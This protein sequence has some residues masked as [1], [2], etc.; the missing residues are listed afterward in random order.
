MSMDKLAS[1]GGMVWDVEVELHGEH[2]VITVQPG[3]SILESAEMAGLTLSYEC[4]RGNCTSCAAKILHGSS[5]FV[6]T[7]AEKRSGTSDPEGY[8]LTCC[9]FPVGPG[10]KLSLGRNPDMWEDFCAR[11]TQ[12]ETREML[13]E[14]SSEI[15]MDYANKYPEEL[16]EYLSRQMPE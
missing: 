8:V 14:A 7:H 4:R 13:S 2:K 15:R 3:D 6:E 10:V 1:W 9:S 16:R 5:P 12:E 11:F